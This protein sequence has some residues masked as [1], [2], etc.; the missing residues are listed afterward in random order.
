MKYVPKKL[1]LK[2]RFCLQMVCQ[3]LCSGLNMTRH[4]N[5]IWQKSPSVEVCLM[6]RGIAKELLHPLMLLASLRLMVQSGNSLLPPGCCSLRCCVRTATKRQTLLVLREPRSGLSQPT[7]RGFHL[8]SCLCG[9]RVREDSK[10]SGHLWALFYILQCCS[11]VSFHSLSKLCQNIIFIALWETI[12]PSPVR[13]LPTQLIPQ[14]DF[15]RH[16]LF[17]VEV[18]MFFFSLLHGW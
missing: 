7:R 15:H 17:S 8:P 12:Q 6:D 11:S 18:S 5:V 10:D 9:F 3:E 1:K 2:P 13:T 16:L 14:C 4:N